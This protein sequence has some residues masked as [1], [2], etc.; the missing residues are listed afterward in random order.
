MLFGSK[1]K[2]QSNPGNASQNKETNELGNCASSRLNNRN[3][4]YENG[5]KK[6]EPGNFSNT[7]QNSRYRSN[8]KLHQPAVQVDSQYLSDRERILQ[9]YGYGAGSSPSLQ[10]N[11]RGTFGIAG[12]TPAEVRHSHSMA[13]NSSQLASD[14]SPVQYNKPHS[15]GFHQMSHLPPGHVSSHLGHSPTA[16]LQHQEPG[17]VAQYLDRSPSQ[18]GHSPSQSSPSYQGANGQRIRHEAGSYQ[19]Y[20][21]QHHQETQGDTSSSMTAHAA[22][23][24]QGQ[25]VEDNGLADQSK[26]PSQDVGHH[27]DSEGEQ[28]PDEYYAG[29]PAV[30]IKQ[31]KT[32]GGNL[33]CTALCPLLVH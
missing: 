33:P 9:S 1:R 31:T 8:E 2:D 15:V 29:E 26:V 14:R 18:L 22:R 23:Q 3:G 16:T 32:D 5:P 21:A 10:S 24:Q 30:Y 7:L 27:G 12:G 17:M 19:F 25:N 13:A 4:E 20:P 6:P 28:D 11:T